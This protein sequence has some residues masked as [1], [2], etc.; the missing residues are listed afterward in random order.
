MAEA[1]PRKVPEHLWTQGATP[2]GNENIVGEYLTG[3][4]PEGSGEG[5]N[6]HSLPQHGADL[7]L[8][9]TRSC[10]RGQ[11]RPRAPEQETMPG[12]FLSVKR[13]PSTKGPEPRSFAR[14]PEGPVGTTAEVFPARSPS[15]FMMETPPEAG[16]KHTQ[17]NDF[18]KQNRAEGRAE[19]PR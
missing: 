4:R 1:S 7:T 16:S 19:T 6:G 3:Q 8:R 11:R 15:A 5:P 17:C 10:R 14:R 18:P 13:F 2:L 9:P 12:E